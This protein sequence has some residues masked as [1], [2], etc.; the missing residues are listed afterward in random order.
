MLLMIVILHLMIDGS[1]VFG[2]IFANFVRFFAIIFGYLLFVNVII[3][4]HDKR[5]W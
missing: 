5:V 4:S 3:S 1:N 2:D